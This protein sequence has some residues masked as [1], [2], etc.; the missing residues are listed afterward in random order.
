MPALPAEEN[1]RKSYKILRKKNSHNFFYKFHPLLG[2]PFGNFFSIPNARLSLY[3][4]NYTAFAC[5]TSIQRC[6]LLKFEI[7]FSILNM[8]KATTFV[9]W[10]KKRCTKKEWNCFC[11]SK[12]ASCCL[13]NRLWKFFFFF[14]VIKIS[15]DGNFLKVIQTNLI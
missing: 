5:C 6:F 14:W 3:I 1:P 10:S 9:W 12:V 2:A 8:T 15:K 13:N 4:S 11:V 7:L